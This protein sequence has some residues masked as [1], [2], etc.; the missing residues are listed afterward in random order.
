MLYIPQGQST[1]LTETEQI[2]GPEHSISVLIRG[3][4]KRECKETNL[5]SRSRYIER[6]SWY[7]YTY[8]ITKLYPKLDS[9]DYTNTIRKYEDAQGFCLV[10]KLACLGDRC[11]CDVYI[12][13]N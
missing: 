7:D 1:S 8:R 5:P 10:I 12:Q 2:N 11:A 13:L 4:D 3:Y 9:A 6:N